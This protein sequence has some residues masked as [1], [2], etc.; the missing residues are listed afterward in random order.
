MIPPHIR[1]L[2]Q[3]RGA[4]VGFRPD[5]GRKSV[6]QGASDLC[7]KYALANALGYRRIPDMVP[8]GV[9]GLLL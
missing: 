9:E 5:T 1:E 8:R 2:D 4:G 7:Q 6:H 3:R